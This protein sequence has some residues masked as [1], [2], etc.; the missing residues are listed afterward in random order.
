MES[1]LQFLFVLYLDIWKQFIRN[2]KMRNMM[3]LL[4]KSFLPKATPL[5]VKYEEISQFRKDGILIFEQLVPQETVAKIRE[6]LKEKSVYN[7]VD[8]DF[9][10]KEKT[11]LKLEDV[12]ITKQ[13]KLKYFDA[14]IANC[15]EIV[16]IANSEKILA[17]V[18]AYFG[19]KPTIATMSSWWTKAGSDASEKFYDDMFHRD[20]D[21]YKFV[22]LFVYLNDVGAES[23]AHCF[24]KGSHIS[25]KLTE[26]RILTDADI[27][28][29]FDAK[30]C[31]PLPAKAGT[32]ILE[33]TWGIH[34]ALPCVKGE[35]LLLHIL[36]SITAFN[37]D[38]SPPH[39]V[40]KNVYE[41][42]AYSNR[43]YLYP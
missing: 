11:P 37:A 16:E 24:V 13:T 32:G 2:P 17:L 41:V 34:R 9:G 21:D 20:V 43:V 26:R 22:K 40:A 29:N 31:L 19:C 28:Q 12:Q 35:R 38:A 5:P 23:G 3:Y 25:K 1:I 14:D 27:A 42:D 8:A 10:G 18:S 4:V 30:D 36:Y 7:W 15:K 39:P 6:Y 33:D